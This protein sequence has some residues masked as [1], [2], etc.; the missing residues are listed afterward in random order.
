[1]LSLES[2]MLS[3]ESVMLSLESVMLSRSRLQ[4]SV[5]FLWDKA[6]LRRG[7][8]VAI[9]PDTAYPLDVICA[10][11]HR[12]TICAECGANRLPPIPVVVGV[13]VES[14]LAKHEE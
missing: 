8:P 10:P 6:P 2:V 3:L 13:V 11:S 14:L 5:V 1:M 4:F 9:H 12:V 7:E